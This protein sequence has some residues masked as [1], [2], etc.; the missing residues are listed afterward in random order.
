MSTIK[1]VNIFLFEDVLMKDTTNEEGKING[2]DSN[3][4][5][6]EFLFIDSVEKSVFHFLLVLINILFELTVIFKIISSSEYFYLIH[7]IE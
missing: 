6:D 4:E 2:C 1:A 3:E 7:R 5:T